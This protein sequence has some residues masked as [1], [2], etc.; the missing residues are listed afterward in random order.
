LSGRRLK[1]ER[2]SAGGLGGVWNALGLTPM[3]ARSALPAQPSDLHTD[4]PQYVTAG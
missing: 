2:E 4:A 3:P 1:W